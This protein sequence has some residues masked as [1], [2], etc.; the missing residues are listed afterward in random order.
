MRHVINYIQLNY[1]LQL[2]H[3]WLIHYPNYTHSSIVWDISLLIRQNCSLSHEAMRWGKI[4]CEEF[5]WGHYC[6]LSN[7]C[8]PSNASRQRV[9][10]GLRDVFLLL[11]YGSCGW[12]SFVTSKHRDW[13]IVCDA[14]FAREPMWPSNAQKYTETLTVCIT[15]SSEHWCYAWWILG[16]SSDLVIFNVI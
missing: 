6:S 12:W 14:N 5:V 15:I 8:C 13:R 16:W 1:K 3:L 11:T 7:V 10:R 9:L 2:I 4:A